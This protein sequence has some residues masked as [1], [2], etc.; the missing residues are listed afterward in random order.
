VTTQAPARRDELIVLGLISIGLVSI[1]LAIV[2]GLFIDNNGL[3]NWAENVLVSVAT[4]TALKLGDCISALVALA[5]GRVIETQGTQLAG[6]A[7]MAPAKPA[8]ASAREAADQVAA[9]A[10]EEAD[11]IRSSAEFEQARPEG[12]GAGDLPRRV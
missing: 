9:A 2:L 1:I 5:N 4:A 10:D 12:A 3:P 11:Q 8:P 6:S 7:P